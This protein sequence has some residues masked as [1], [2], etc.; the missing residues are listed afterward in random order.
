MSAGESARMVDGIAVIGMA[1]RFPGARDIPQF[2]ENLKNGIESITGFDDE[3]LHEGAAKNS[4]N[5]VRARP[6][7]Q[8]AEMF[9]PAFFGM[10]PKEAEVMDPQQRVFLE[11]CWQ[12]FEDAGYDPLTYDGL[13]G[14]YAGCSTN[15][16]FLEHLC[17]TRDFV[18]DYAAS[19]PVGNYQTMLGNNRD[20]LATRVSYKLNLKGP[21][22]T[23]QA[24]CATSLVAICQAC[25][26]LL[27]Y[28]ADMALAGGVSIT[29][30][31]NRGYLYQS[32]GIVSPDGHCRAFDAK[33]Q[34]T[35]FGAGA[36]AVLLKRFE[37]A[38]AD[39][40]R[41]HAVI[42]GFGV[43]ND[44]SV[45]VGYTAPSVDGQARVVAM[46][47]ANAGVNPASITYVEAHG[48]G[49]SLG[50][51]IE[52][53]ALTQAFRAGTEAKQFCA[54]G[55]A[56][57]NIGHLDVASGVAGFIKAVLSLRHKKLV[58][59]LHFKTPNPRIDFANSP[60]YVNT[61]LREW[62]TAGMPRRAGVSAF[63]IG[64]TNAH[65][66]LEEAPERGSVASGRSSHLLPL[67][68][69]TA[70]A[71]DSATANLA[72]AFRENPEISLDG[73]AYTLQAGRH[74]FEHRRMLV[75]GGARDAISALETNDPQRV[76]TRA[77]QQRNLG[78][79]FLFPGQGAQYTGMGREL[80]ASE[81]VFRRH[82][83]E[84]REIL[85]PHMGLD[86]W[87]E[88]EIEATLLAQ[89]SIFVIEYALARLWMA[90]GIQPQAMIGHSVGEFAAA[91]IAGVF[92][93]EDALA[94]IARRGRLMQD[95]PGGA[96]LSVRLPEAEL[97][98][99]LT[100]ELSIA[101]INGPSLCVASGPFD[102]IESLEETLRSR[103]AAFRRL[104]ASHA[105]HS[106]MM[107]PIIEPFTERVRQVRLNAPRIPYISSVTG[108][109][110]TGIEATDPHYWARHF[111][112]PVRFSEG[113]SHFRQKAGMALIEV[114]PGNTLKTLAHQHAG[115]TDQAIVSSLPDV[116]RKP[117]DG[118]TM[119][120]ALGR[121][122]LAGM[123]PDWP[124]VHAHAPRHRVAL[125]TY[126]FERKRYC[127]E[128]KS[129][130]TEIMPQIQQRTNRQSRI[131][132]MLTSVFEDLS[133]M[134]FARTD[135]SATFLEMGFD[136]LFLTQVTQ[137][138]QNKFKVKITFRQLLG[139]QSTL[140]SLA[141]F[142]DENLPAEA[143]AE[144]L[145]KSNPT[146]VS[147]P[148]GG[149]TAME[150][151]VQQHLQAMTQLMAQQL[152]MVRNAGRAIEPAPMPLSS[153]TPPATPEFKPFGPYKP[154]QKGPTGNL[155]ARQQTYLDN[156][157]ERYTRRTAGSKRFTQAHREILADP[158]VAAG[159]RSQWKDLVYPIVTTRS[160]G[161]KLWD[162]DGNEYIDILNGFGP[163]LL[164]H[165]PDFVVKAVEKQLHE[166][167]EIGPQTP[168]AGKVAALICEMTGME[169][170]TFTN[171]GS[172]AVMA[173]L[174]VARTV[175]GRDKVVLF[176]GSYHGT[177]DEVLVKGIKKAG[178][179]HSAPIAPGIPSQKT[180]NVIVLDYGT[181][182][183]L[184][185][186]RAHADDLAAVLIETVQSRH[187]ALRPKEFLEEIR[188]IT[189]KSGSALIF[190]E[191]VT[192]FRVHP[193]GA[194]AYFGIR[195]DLATY[196]KVV[197][198]GYPIGVLAGKA[199][200]MDALDGGMWN[201]DDDSF[202][203][204]GVTF[205]A[206]TFVRHPLALAA[207]LAVLTHL[208]EQGPSLQATLQDKTAAL[209]KEL[210]EF[211]EERQVPTRIET[212]SSWFYFSFPTDQRFGTLLYY[213]LREKGV[214]IQE[215]FPCFLTTA[216]TERDLADV[217]RAFK[218]SIL[219]MQDGGVLPAPEQ[220]APL[221]E[222][223]MEI[224]LSAQLGDEASCAY[225]ESF[226]L[227]MNG[228]LREAELREALDEI[229]S[230]HEAL[231]TT[232]S[233]DGGSEQCVQHAHP[234]LRIDVPLE[235][236][237]ALDDA[238]RNE[239]IHQ[240]IARDART[241]F[242]LTH[243]PL[244]R[245]TLI[246]AA[247]DRHLL[248]FT[249]HHIVCDGW[250]I[251]VILEELSTIYTAKC[252]GARGG[253]PQP[254]R[255]TEYATSQSTPDPA[256][257]QYWRDRFAKPAPV[258][259]LP[260]D[261]PR[262]GVKGYRGA[263][264]RGTIDAST[265]KDLKR[266]GAQH[267][268]TLF[269]TLLAGFHSL[270][271]RLT[272]QEDIVIGI[273]TAGQSLLDG[274]TLV[275]HCVN[276][277]PLRARISGADLF[278]D[279]LDQTKRALLD[280]YEHRNYTYGTLVR[281]L[282]LP[283][284]PSRLP[285]I[286]VQFNLERV[287]AGLNFPGLEVQ[288]DPNPKAFVNFDLFLNVMESDDGLAIDCDYNTGLF[289]E[290]T[291]A[292]WLS[293]YRTQLQ[294]VAANTRQPIALM[295]LLP[296]A[297][298]ERLLIDW[299]RTAAD[300]PRIC[301]HQWFEEQAART[302]HAIAVVF[303]D[304]RLT[305]AELNG[306]ANQLAH[307]LAKLGVGPG[308]LVGICVER[309]IETIVGLLGILKAG[310]AYLPLDPAYPRERIHFIIQESK[311]AVLLTQEPLAVDLREVLQGVG[312]RVVCLDSDWGLIG[313]E[314]G[315][316]P[317]TVV[318]PSDLAYVI[319]TSG[320]TGKPKGVQLQHNAFVNLLNSMRKKP[321][322]TDRDTLLAVTT[323]SFDIAGLELFLPLV[324]GAKLVIASRE[325]T[326]DGSKLLAQLKN[327][328]ITALQGTPSTWRL[329]IE[330]G[331]RDTPHL[332]MLCGGEALPRELAD[333]L[334]DRGGELW[335]MYGPTETT[336]WSAVSLVEKG[337]GPVLIGPPVDNTQFYI[338]DAHG[339]PVPVGVPGE[340]H[341]GGDG[342][343][344]GYFERPELTR[345]KF[346]PN[347]FSQ[348][349]ERLYKTGDLV[350]HMPDGRI[351][352]LGRLDNQVKIR[353][354]RIELGEIESILRR[355]PAVRD[356]AVMAREDVPGEKKLAAYVSLA[357]ENPA[358]SKQ[359]REFLAERL[360]DYM[361]PSAVVVV[362][363]L[364]LLPNGKVDRKSLP[365]PDMA[366]DSNR[367]EFVAPRSAAEKILAGIWKDVLRLKQV[368]VDDNLF[369]LGADSIHLFQIAARAN[370]A[371]LELT[372]KQLLEH[373]TLA[374][375]AQALEIAR[376]YG[377]APRSK[378]AA[379][380][381]AAH[382]QRVPA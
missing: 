35:V 188:A 135:A 251:N 43:N 41:V 89:P 358:D 351:E 123:Q 119:W 284:D 76:I 62:E 102:E 361:L 231:R 201:Y 335:N 143:L 354:F 175:T 93:L 336:I 182:E 371:G 245:I 366:R 150:R 1:G 331:W 237:A 15:T 28:Q 6:M 308:V 264:Y 320:S 266:A 210:N 272:G 276:F 270:L 312:A 230:R 200:F 83:D 168:L 69:K 184:E 25:Q 45:K 246:R 144:V 114:G 156:L 277:L 360:P 169:R 7:L 152:D 249:A 189:E 315:G 203:E 311:V 382:R 260:V 181:P 84:C 147:A 160:R 323:L 19:Y 345:E 13:A 372:P 176:A 122:W 318:T 58:P 157:I 338:L 20:F 4:P 250:S 16:Y 149:E 340:L 131:A 256:T 349:P 333:Q 215:G 14:V 262:P 109:W 350:R 116:S 353:G 226:T 56:K 191:V 218:E 253:L 279:L 376:Q 98:P 59:T 364:P 216:H 305:Y 343:A 190:D 233:A 370:A 24:G 332:K 133:G 291:I 180:E 367:R 91:C 121:L 73:A 128:S 108:T 162:I 314:S 322:I 199:A 296:P 177:F 241:A 265:Y 217:A 105:F 326:F 368:G 310:A 112:M 309:S 23:L 321:G 243:G 275:G 90:W 8:D 29:F 172:E 103:D 239:R 22:F 54:I 287:G 11:C 263:T 132:T 347:P 173:A 70:S 61:E 111:R 221:T 81:P 104:H 234:L 193:G 255:F 140:Q 118:A 379:V 80:H 196:G 378:I 34:G 317:A 138:V 356:A 163:I 10:Y 269:A 86:P 195:A 85:R 316:E 129:P 78:A 290:S 261:R 165:S 166:G 115:D 71:L 254:S 268:C 100:P 292:R 186:I 167:I 74:A 32:D 344:R 278:S 124:A 101:A 39:G 247:Q 178:V 298:R 232:F 273:P 77:K 362:D 110:I 339:Q 295:P 205:F 67:S 285:L 209:A 151:L 334:L 51:P 95:L 299:N 142:L 38:V 44:G 198:G 79:A 141:A 258:L 120:N 197:G 225:N 248:L 375:V 235:D 202:P 355:H 330:A 271:A 174:R 137:S 127:V 306:K 207:A 342:L 66:V 280:A 192:G 117:S 50:D 240:M 319:Y 146:P 219:E 92:S 30:P 227:R 267:G 373:R 304:R 64:G 26:G 49:T 363:A 329:L 40:D 282:A 229:I 47:H 3:D 228:Q 325:A 158:R 302:P 328:G 289:D 82:V 324:T 94:L 242:D 145:P 179:P 65:V 154:V 213:H 57:T 21:S 36:G 164:G 72:N 134:D 42:R 208:K 220:A 381:R 106:A 130:V 88:Q 300:Y 377:A 223:Q 153:A 252:A 161:S 341:I 283:R 63:G 2:W 27:T 170:A 5:Y 294:A 37:D 52:I 236:L 139:E 55:T 238:A 46:A 222:A 53:A 380:S 60:F 365:V 259:D 171:T 159:F 126:P 244:V 359:L 369:E 211:F 303:E 99:L 274:E 212:F 136:S 346:I 281:K 293:C 297:E 214:H 9:D 31:Q 68:A 327:S 357:A 313:K 97:R 113:I 107:D 75:C 185:Y 33:A 224:R 206:G 288:A 48:T 257:E 286:E 187:P 337:A 348:T 307:Y 125:P 204:V 18:Q 194:Q 301:V 148:M 17:P 155:T 352:F 87:A 374:A 12:A 183:S 96:M